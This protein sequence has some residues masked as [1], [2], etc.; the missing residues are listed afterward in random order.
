MTKHKRGRGRPRKAAGE[1]VSHR[2]TPRMRD[3]L[4]MLVHEGL[5]INDA[6]AQAGF[7]PRAIYKAMKDPP[8][9]EF[10]RS[11]LKALLTCAKA[12]AAHALIKELGGENAAARVAAARTILEDDVKPQI[13]SAMAQVPGFS[14]LIV[15]GRA[16]QQTVDI[17]AVPA[18]HARL[19][20]DSSSRDRPDDLDEPE[21]EEAPPL[22]WD[23][24]RGQMVV[25][26]PAA[27]TRAVHAVD[28]YGR[29]R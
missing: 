18:A 2:L 11:E 29:R 9:Q 23:S 10:Y 3:A 4:T 13:A 14:I 24:E 22:R 28:Q 21:R 7:T 8:A 19:V 16:Q 6:A 5:C 17:T 27:D 12:A 26:R 25:G 1:P 20:D 15:D